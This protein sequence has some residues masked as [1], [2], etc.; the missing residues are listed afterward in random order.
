MANEDITIESST[1]RRGEVRLSCSS[2]GISDIGCKRLHNEDSYLSSNA[3]GIW[4]VADGMGGHD[5]GDLA[6]Q[7]L[8]HNLDRI[9]V[10]DTLDD[11]VDLIER[12]I[13]DTN[14]QLN[15]IAAETDSITTIGTTV[16]MMAARGNDGMVMWAGD[17]RV[18][19]IRNNTLEQVSRDHSVVNDLLEKGLI[20]AHQAEGHPDS[21]KI[22]RSVGITDDLD[23]ER[24]TVSILAGDRYLICSDGLTR[25]INDEQ[26]AMIASP[27]VNRKSADSARALIKSALDAGTRDNV[28]VVV[29]D[30]KEAS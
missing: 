16:A 5:A 7:T 13:Q 6:S 12:S 28:T 24:R 17:S 19:R 3:K 4:A 11:C 22:T 30:F 25:E 1:G 26:L 23:I 29:I 8:V 15:D 27:E 18:Y 14:R 20:E 9:V 21:N 10:P 2:Y